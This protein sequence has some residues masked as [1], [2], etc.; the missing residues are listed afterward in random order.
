M[1]NEKTTNE[2]RIV[3]TIEK[4]IIVV[5]SIASISATVS[6]IISTISSLEDKHIAE[7]EARRKNDKRLQ[8]EIDE[9]KETIKFILDSDA[10]K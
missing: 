1:S 8:T 2:K 5:F 9:L 10:I 3:L 4:F 6:G 7:Q